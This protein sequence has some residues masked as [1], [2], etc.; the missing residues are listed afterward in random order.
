MR[1]R[2][3]L[4]IASIPALA[5]AM[6]LAPLPSSQPV[7]AG[8]LYVTNTN[9]TG[10]GSLRQA[11]T[12]ANNNSGGDII[13]FNISGCG[14]VC[15][16]QP[17]SPLPALIDDETIMAG[18]SQPEA[19]PATP[20]TA[21]TIKIQIDGSAAGAAHGLEVNSDGNRIGGLS[22]TGFNG[23]GI[24]ID[25]ASDNIVVGNYIGLEPDGA[26]GNGNDHGISITGSGA[27]SNTIGGTTAAERNVISGNEA[28]GIAMFGTNV[29]WNVVS[30]NYIGTDANGTGALGNDDGI[31]V[32]DGAQSNTFGGDT[33]SER[34]VISGNDYCGLYVN[35]NNISGNIVSGNYIGTNVSGDSALGN[36]LHGVQLT[37]GPQYNT[38][39]G[40]SEGKRNVISGNEGSGVAIDRGTAGHNTV[41]GNYIGTD[42]SGAS[43]LPNKM[44]GVYLSF[45]T[46]FNTVGGDTPGKRNVIS[47][48][49]H[50]GVSIT[51]DSTWNNTIAG[52]YIGTD[53]SGAGPLPN[54]TAGVSLA[55]GPRYNTIGLDNVI[56]YNGQYG[57]SL[58]GATTLS[59]YIMQNSIFGNALGCGHCRL[60]EIIPEYK[61]AVSIQH[62]RNRYLQIR[63]RE[64]F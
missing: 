48:N 59:N 12:D 35:G 46:Q 51:D 18:Y 55:N 47:G 61:P 56:A 13:T 26:T 33:P 37:N 5:L 39:G 41:W 15:L 50:T 3:A 17:S 31:F 20:T 30:G 27:Q 21:A 9:D 8:M 53:A 58:H 38:I 52:N 64:P 23:D 49:E 22:I 34:N 63:V 60:Q 28:E 1:K 45:G 7:R 32:S 6:L 11:I 54:L 57:V 2:Q 43:A 29:K 62:I 4:R 16:I 19:N 36:G 10:P 42:A 25:G 24:Y 44:H 40:T 14:G